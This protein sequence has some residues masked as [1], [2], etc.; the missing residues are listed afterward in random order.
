M[1]LP[2]V[3]KHPLYSLHSFFTLDSRV[4]VSLPCRRVVTSVLFH[5]R[6]SVNFI[7]VWPLDSNAISIG[8][9]FNTIVSNFQRTFDTRLCARF[10]H[11]FRNFEEKFYPRIKK[12]TFTRIRVCFFFLFQLI[13]ISVASVCVCLF[14]FKSEEKLLPAVIHRD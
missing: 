10:S 11:F 13:G 6:I 3:T 14:L 8:S 5:C 4:C 7:S 9:P 12:A 1:E 2:Q